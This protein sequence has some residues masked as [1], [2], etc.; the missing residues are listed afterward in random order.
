MTTMKTLLMAA[1]LTAGVVSTANASTITL[2][3]DSSWLATNVAPAP[4]W[5]TNPFFNT[6]GWISAV[7]HC[8][9]P[10]GGECIWYDGQFTATADA[11]MRRSFTISGPFTSGLLVGGID[12][13]ADIYLNGTLIFSDHN[14]FSQAYGPIDVTPYLVQGLNFFAVHAIDNIPVWGQ[15]HGFLASLD[16]QTPTA[17]AVPEPSSLVL[18]TVGL[19][20][21]AFLRSRR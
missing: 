2:R 19:A 17:D 18:F 16:I 9:D 15:N 6:A 3:T 5:N 20:G 8:N 12:D 4:G 10:V 14:G 21:L 13:D 7:S 1:A 11:W